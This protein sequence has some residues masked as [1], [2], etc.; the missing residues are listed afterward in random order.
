M[1]IGKN[2]KTPNSESKEHATDGPSASNEPAYGSQESL[3]KATYRARKSMPKQREKHVEVL[4]RMVKSATPQ[5]KAILRKNLIVSPNS[6]KKLTFVHTTFDSVKTAL[7]KLKSKRSTDDLK[8]K[9]TLAWA[10]ALVRRKYSMQQCRKIGIGYKLLKRMKSATC[11]SE[12][13]VRK[14]R[15]DALDDTVAKMVRAFYRRSDVSRALPDARGVKRGQNGELLSRKV[16]ERSVTSAHELFRAENPQTAI[17]RA[18]FAEL[19]PVDVMP[20]TCNRKRDCLCEYCANIELKLDAL[21]MFVAKYRL[22]A[23]S[24]RDKYELSRITLCP[25]GETGEYMRTCL[26]RKCGNCGTSSLEEHLRPLLEAQTDAD[27]KYD[28]W[29][30]IT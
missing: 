6:K 24:I 17:S 21:K 2:K 9:R 13:D 18:K 1:K 19:R 16:L 7:E 3:R 10:L 11:S 8:K 26:E 12:L 14:R 27:V 22:E 28:K 25:P 15:K 29:E 20:T 4:I 23:C 5:K 30:N